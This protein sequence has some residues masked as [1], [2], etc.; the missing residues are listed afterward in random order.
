MLMERPLNEETQ[1]L[2]DPQLVTE[3][4][5]LRGCAWRQS[6]T[7]RLSLQL[8]EERS[9]LTWACAW[10]LERSRLTWIYAWQWSEAY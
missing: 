7:A 4:G 1:T 10:A 3:C 5:R 8:V 9:C 2:K 6:T